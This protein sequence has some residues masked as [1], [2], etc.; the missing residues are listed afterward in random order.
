MVG[1]RLSQV[2]HPQ[3]PS[4]KEDT[5][6][7]MIPQICIVPTLQDQHCFGS[8]HS[9]VHAAW[10]CQKELWVWKPHVSLRDLIGALFSLA[11]GI[12]GS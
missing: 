8:S 11:V 6:M 5:G 4:S 7:Q 9:R 2:S 12:T 1:W 10:L 3:K